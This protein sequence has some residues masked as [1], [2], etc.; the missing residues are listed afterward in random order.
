M[1]DIIIPVLV[2]GKV[3]NAELVKYNARTVIVRLP[4]GRIIKRKKKFI[5]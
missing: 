3:V 5:K 2:S 4:D 1:S